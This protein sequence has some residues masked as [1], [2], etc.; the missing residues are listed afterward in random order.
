MRL[1]LICILWAV[2][3]FALWENLSELPQA[4]YEAYFAEHGG[5][6]LPDQEEQIRGPYRNFIG[7][8]EKGADPIPK[9]YSLKDDVQ[10]V[11]RQRCG[12][13]WAQGAASAFETLISSA[14]KVS[15]FI[16]R[17]QVIDCSGY[18]SCGGGR[19]SLGN[20]VKPRGAV[21]EEDYPYVGRTQRC[22]KSALTYHQSVEDD[23]FRIK[24]LTLPNLQRAIL[25]TGPLEVC[26]SAGAL[27]KGGWVSRNPRGSTNHCY[28]MVGWYDGETHGKPEG[29]YGIILNSWGESWGD[30]GYGYYLLAEDGE[31]LDGSIITE[32]MGIAYKPACTPQPVANAGVDQNL[33]LGELK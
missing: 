26:G 9:E 23:P 17:Q 24:P 29:T 2:P 4:D 20:F 11:F 27:G 1:F 30:E 22:D 12:D 16:S 28:A 32:A 33:I 8:G 19:I 15:T 7:Y 6:Y 10:R 3:C 25:E 5:G 18:G 31:N 14:D 13:C 21:Y